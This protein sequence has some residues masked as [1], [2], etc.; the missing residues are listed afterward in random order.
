MCCVAEGSLERE[1]DFLIDIAG[2]HQSCATNNQ[3]GVYGYADYISGSSSEV[4]SAMSQSDIATIYV[5]NKGK[6]NCGGLIVQQ[7]EA[8]ILH[9]AAEFTEN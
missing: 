2:E 5:I 9:E 1:L 8:D 6:L 4:E 7:I 3:Q